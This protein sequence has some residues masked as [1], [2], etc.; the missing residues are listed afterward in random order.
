MLSKILIGQGVFLRDNNRNPPAVRRKLEKIQNEPISSITLV[1]TPL[2]RATSA[3]L[4]VASGGQLEQRLKETNIDKLFH[5]SMYINHKY[6]LEKNEVIKLSQANPITKN[7]ETLDIPINDQ[8]T[9]GQLITNTQKYMGDKYAPYDAIDNNCGV[10]VN[11][12]L[13]ANGL[14]NENS[15]IFT[16]QKVRD[17]Y[18]KFPSLSKKLTDAVTTLGAIIDRQIQGEG[19][20]YF[21]NY[22]IT[23][24]K[25]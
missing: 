7:S 20:G 4:N 14:S 23:E 9:I 6:N 10:F 8:L 2:A 21:Y 3:L 13:Q 22:R 16:H 1:R 24:I 17:L 15:D 25:V 11:S 18:D 19:A 12:I 5:L